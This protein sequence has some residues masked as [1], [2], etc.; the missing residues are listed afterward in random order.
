MSLPFP[1]LEA[2]IDEAACGIWGQ[3]NLHCEITSLLARLLR[4]PTS[5][6][7]LSGSREI[8]RPLEMLFIAV[9]EG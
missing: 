9:L 6:I 2:V 4:R 1:G 5:G 3:G 7:V 8:K